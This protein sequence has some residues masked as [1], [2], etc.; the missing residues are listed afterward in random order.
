MRRTACGRVVASVRVVHTHTT[1]PTTS[2][3]A[4]AWARGLFV[5]SPFKCERVVTSRKY[6]NLYCTQSYKY[7]QTYVL[8]TYIHKY[9]TG[10][11]VSSAINSLDKPKAGAKT[12][13]ALRAYWVGWNVCVSEL[14][15]AWL[16]CLQRISCRYEK[17]NR[18]FIRLGCWVRSCVSLAWAGSAEVPESVKLSSWLCV[19]ANPSA[20]LRM[21]GVRN[22]CADFL[23]SSFR[24]RQ[25]DTFMGLCINLHKKNENFHCRRLHYYAV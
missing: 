17:L 11:D 21:N 16:V 8:T 13:L 22:C 12:R 3:R 23:S 7:V 14:L 2:P 9:Y 18:I 6:N 4:G 10:S 25:R 1:A 20:C 24:G 5:I 15:L 19:L